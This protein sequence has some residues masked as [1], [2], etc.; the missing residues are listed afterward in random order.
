MVATPARLND[1]IENHFADIELADIKI[2]VLDEVDC[3][4]SMGFESQVIHALIGIPSLRGE[5]ISASPLQVGMIEEV[6]PAK[7]QNLMFSATI[8]PKIER[9]AKGMMTDTIS[10]TVGEVRRT[11]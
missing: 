1:V 6:L 7:R 4:L 3:L 9:L 5:R 11:M 2:F 10:I 8:P